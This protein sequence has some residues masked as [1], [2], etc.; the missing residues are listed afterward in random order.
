MWLNSW[1]DNGTDM[2]K[3]VK[4]DLMVFVTVTDYDKNNF[5][6]VNNT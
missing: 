5:S 2:I 4:R 3:T 6:V 1:Q